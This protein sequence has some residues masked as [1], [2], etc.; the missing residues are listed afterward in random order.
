MKKCNY[1]F[2]V[3]KKHFYSDYTY[4]CDHW[5]KD[6]YTEI[7]LGEDNVFYRHSGSDVWHPFIENGDYG[8]SL[9]RDEEEVKMIKNKYDEYVTQL[10]EKEFGL[11]TE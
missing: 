5:D 10:L 11:T 8:W 1:L 6:D 4:R 7:K 3:G 9:Y 2:T